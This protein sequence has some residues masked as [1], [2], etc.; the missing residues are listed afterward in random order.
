MADDS[1]VGTNPEAPEAQPE[2]A[3]A[4]PTA[5]TPDF[6]AEVTAL[7]SRQAG[8]DA[9]ITALLKSVEDGEKARNDL[10]A[11]LDAALQGQAG[12]DE[13]QK[14]LAAKDQEIARLAA[15]ATGN[16]RARKFPETARE[17]GAETIAKM[18]EVV[19]AALEAR[20]AGVPAESNEP[21]T[22]V[23]NNAPRTPAPANKPIEE[24]T[25]AELKAHGAS[26]FANLTWDGIVQE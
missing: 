8:Q 20:L 10:Q 7:R 17:L 1:N 11:R 5:G 3:T 4:A 2:A 15:L 25:L 6:V 12:Q 22:P 13:F 19:L 26:A 14:A 24:M 23:G 9:K 18:D 21:P 16:E